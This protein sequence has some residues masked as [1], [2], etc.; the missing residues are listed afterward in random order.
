MMNRF[1]DSTSSKS[2]EQLR[3]ERD[4]TAWK[5]AMR[6]ASIEKNDS[7]P[8][9]EQIVKYRQWGGDIDSSLSGVMFNIF[10]RSK[11]DRRFMLNYEKKPDAEEVPSWTSKLVNNQPYFE[12]FSEATEWIRQKAI[13]YQDDEKRIQSLK[14]E[15]K[16]T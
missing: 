15:I 13:E 6:G 16:K 7:S 1:E 11:D 2:E 5:E 14:E 12:T 4:A 8:K 10:Q 9:N 3:R